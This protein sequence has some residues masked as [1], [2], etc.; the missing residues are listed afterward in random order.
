MGST[1]VDSTTI[2]GGEYELV[3]VGVS[4]KTMS[5]EKVGE[6]VHYGQINSAV[7]KNDPNHMYED[8]VNDFVKDIGGESNTYASKYYAQ[9]VMMKSFGSFCK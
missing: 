4:T 9:Q 6:A 3:N 5:A 2:L 8:Y 1:E 7:L